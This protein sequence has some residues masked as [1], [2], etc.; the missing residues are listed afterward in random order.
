MMALVVLID[1]IYL[2]K[3]RNYQNLFLIFFLIFF[4]L[5]LSF[6]ACRSLDT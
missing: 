3:K 2:L 4:K 5:D 1:Q 6:S